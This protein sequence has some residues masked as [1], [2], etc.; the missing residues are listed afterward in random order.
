MAECTYNNKK[1]AK[2]SY[3]SFEL[4]YSFHLQAF[5]KEDVNLYF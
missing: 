2:I 5:L 1:N 4:N 3:I